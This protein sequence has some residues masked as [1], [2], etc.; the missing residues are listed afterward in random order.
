M[1]TDEFVHVGDG[2]LAFV[3]RTRIEFVDSFAKIVDAGTSGVFGKGLPKF[4]SVDVN[5]LAGVLLL[6]VIVGNGTGSE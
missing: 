2:P 6:E 4:R 5:I 1:F 3:F